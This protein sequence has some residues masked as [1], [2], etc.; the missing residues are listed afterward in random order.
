MPASN[1][2]RDLQSH[3]AVSKYD[4]KERFSVIASVAYVTPERP[5]EPQL[6][7]VDRG[8]THENVH[9]LKLFG[10]P[11]LIKEYAGSSTFIEW[12]RRSPSVT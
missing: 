9:Y 2:D 4:H 10:T 7:S 1:L 8:L 3:V 6:I 12:L 5:L 11:P